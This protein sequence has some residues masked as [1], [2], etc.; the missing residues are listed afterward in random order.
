MLSQYLQISGILGERKRGNS[1]FLG[2]GEL[3]GL[4]VISAGVNWRLFYVCM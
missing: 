1:L 4:A 2:S 3:D